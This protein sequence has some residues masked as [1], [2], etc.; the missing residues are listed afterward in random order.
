M[1]WSFRLTSK[2]NIKADGTCEFFCETVGEDGTI[3]PY[4]FEGKPEDYHGLAKAHGLTTARE[5]EVATAIPVGEELV[6]GNVPEYTARITSWKFVPSIPAFSVGYSIIENGVDVATG[7]IVV[8][9][10]GLIQQSVAAA[11]ADFRDKKA[12]FDAIPV[13]QLNKIT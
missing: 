1:D 2:G 6:L 10:A 8:A 11:V 5:H 3:L 9:E 12:E 7:D 13:G 4:S